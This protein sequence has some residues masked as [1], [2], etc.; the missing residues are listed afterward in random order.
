MPTTNLLAPSKASLNTIILALILLASTLDKLA[1]I[2]T[3]NNF[4]HSAI[5]LLFILFFALNV[6]FYSKLLMAFLVPILFLWLSFFSNLDSSPASGGFH[7]A[8]CVTI[9]YLILSLS[10]VPLNF[11]LMRKCIYCLLSLLL[12]LF[13]YPLKEALFTLDILSTIH[14]LQKNTPYGNP[15]ASSLNFYICLVLSLIFIR[16][17]AL[18]FFSFLFTTLI[19]TTA[20]RAGFFTA[21]L[22]LAGS[23]LFDNSHKKINIF[24]RG[25]L[26]LHFKKII[27]I[28]LIA[29]L[30][31]TF[32]PY[33]YEKLQARLLSQ[34]LFSF[35]ANNY[36]TQGRD[37]IWKKA[38]D[39]GNSSY[40]SMLL[41]IGPAKAGPA[42][43]R[44]SHSSY[45]EAIVSN[46]WL[47]FISNVAAM[48]LLFLKHSTQKNRSFLILGSAILIYGSCETV[49]FNGI[50]SLWSLLIFLSTYFLA[51]EPSNSAYQNADTANQ[52]QSVAG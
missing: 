2:S 27:P 40:H 52:Q 9:S 37:I 45:I 22:T 46:G 24:T 25:F 6:Q 49:L 1:T 30:I 41:G 51:Y 4:F 17:K 21:V 48:T 19:L 20:S 7:S 42:I 44:G 8:S 18:W 29:S 28:V 33:S 32:I 3:T 34:S 10:A 15:N 38:L 35:S 47:F 12:V 14:T 11:I 13:L 50:S 5:S 39:I 16:K 23:A 43:G 26:R 31:Y 36:Q